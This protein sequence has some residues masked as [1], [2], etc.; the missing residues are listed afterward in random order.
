MAEKV[1][2]Q[3]DE[4]QDGQMKQVS[5]GGRTA[6]LL[7]QGGD[8]YAIGAKC[9]HYGAPLEDGLLHEGRIIC[10]WHRACFDA[11]TGD[12]QEP[13]ALDALANFE[14]AVEGEDVVVTVP[15]EAPSERT[16]PMARCNPD[17]DDRHFVIVGGGAAG[18]A[19]AEAL[20]Q[21]GV[22]GRISVITKEKEIPYDRPD[23]SKDF[24]ASTKRSKLPA[25]RSR[26]FYE[27]HDVELL[28]GRTVAS[29]EVNDRIVEL[30][31]G[32]SM[33]AD[34]LLLATG[35]R[36]RRLDVEGGGLDNVLT[37]RSFR[38]CLRIKEAAQEGAA[39]VVVGASF[40]GMETAW[41]LADRGVKVTVVA[42]ESVPFERVLGG[43]VGGM[44]QSMH[45]EQGVRFAL[46][47]TIDRFEGE[48]ALEAAVLD[49]GTRLEAD[50]VLQGVGVTPVT[51]YLQGVE[52]NDDGSVSVNANLQLARGVWAA[53]DIARFPDWRTGEPIRIEHWRLAEQHGRV[54]AM[55]MAGRE[56]PFRS[57]PFFWTLHGHFS[58]NYVG[59]VSDWDEVILQGDPADKKFLAYFV[60]DGRVLALA[61][62][63]ETARIAAALHLIEKGQMPT[64]DEVREGADPRER[65]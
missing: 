36:P 14:V 57:A 41:R 61:G 27:E 11:L 60:K 38:D 24:L 22:E 30:E 2:A 34:A 23:L 45:Q 55:N 13:P 47:H 4:L 49:D 18:N 56:V 62:A 28:T 43:D 51:D 15:D 21:E 1:V 48:G 37:L 25:L 54:A 64:P 29:V 63:R 32:S 59:Y 17:R 46:G 26:D 31:D 3:V 20:R 19:A 39:A 16:M 12:V 5:V 33:R 40:I 53:G 58:L 8:Y 52:L 9:T 65:L 44:F 6:L 42:P 35:G 7:R 50:F 10:P